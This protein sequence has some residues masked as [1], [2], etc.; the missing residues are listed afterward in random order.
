M[1]SRNCRCSQMPEEQTRRAR[2]ARCRPARFPC[3]SVERVLSL[4]VSKR[5][6]TAIRCI[7]E[8]FP[9]L[10]TNSLI[11]LKLHERAGKCA[12]TTGKNDKPAPIKARRKLAS[13]GGS[14]KI[15]RHSDR[16]ACARVGS[17]KPRRKKRGVK[18][19]PRV[20]CAV[21]ADRDCIAF[22][23]GGDRR[24]RCDAG[25]PAPGDA[26]QAEQARA[27]QP[28]RGGNRHWHGCLFVRTE[29]ER[30]VRNDRTAPTSSFPMSSAEHVPT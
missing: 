16:G 20:G 24:R 4:P 5:W 8:H 19:A 15:Q 17:R 9:C 18:V 3:A 25:V 13:V 11:P 30:D 6:A 10:G 7:V 12:N 27:K 29:Q 22:A 28:D 21:S 14:V 23:L 2:L 26:D 1:A